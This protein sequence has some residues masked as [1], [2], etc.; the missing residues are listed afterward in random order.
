VLGDWRE[1]GDE[2]RF[3]EATESVVRR[4]SDYTR[5]FYILIAGDSTALCRCLRRSEISFG[6]T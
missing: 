3:G 4:A 6:K 2:V 1:K 5:Q